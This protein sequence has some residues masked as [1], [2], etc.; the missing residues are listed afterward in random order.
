MEDDRECNVGG[1][2][3]GSKD[4]GQRESFWLTQH[5]LPC[6]LCQRHLHLNP[7]KHSH[8]RQLLKS[9]LS[10]KSSQHERSGVFLIF[11]ILLLNNWGFPYMLKITPSETDV[12][13]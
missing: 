2:E 7:H 8:E 9:H 6:Q 4:G 1:L 11:I 3:K 12:S 5:P 10:H 13:A